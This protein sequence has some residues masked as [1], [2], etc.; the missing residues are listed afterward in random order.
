MPGGFVRLPVEPNIILKSYL[1][2]IKELM[3]LRSSE[4]E[5]WS[6]RKHVSICVTGS[7]CQCDI[8]YLDRLEVSER[9]KEHTTRVT[10][11]VSCKHQKRICY[12]YCSSPL[13]HVDTIF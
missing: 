13:Q 5:L 1:E 8:D 9:L 11:S 4:K 3:T 2:K 10:Y 12:R 6:K 7:L